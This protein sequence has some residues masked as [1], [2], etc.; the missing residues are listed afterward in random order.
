MTRGFP[1]LGDVLLTTEAPLGEVAQI[2][3]TRV[4]P[5]QRMILLKA[6]EAKIRSDFLFWHFRSD[7]G[8][9]ELWTRASG[10]TA[11]GIR[12]DRLRAS[13]V[14]VPPL[15][16]QDRIVAFIRDALAKFAGVEAE[17]QKQIC[18]LQERRAALI[19]AA[20]TGKIDVRGLVPQ[21][22]AVAA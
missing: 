6:D 18:L 11:S 5:G 17:V 22:E 2:E 14:L 7:F 13:A 20:V 15:E 4:A 1:A 16:E 3:D 19:S 8:R 21:S 12:S 9:K 10:S